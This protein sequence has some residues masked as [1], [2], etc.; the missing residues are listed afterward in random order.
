MATESVEFLVRRY[1]KQK[2]LHEAAEMLSA[3]AMEVDR[4]IG[5]SSVSLDS[6]SDAILFESFEGGICQ[7]YFHAYDCYRHWACNSLDNVKSELISVCYP[8][9]VNWYVAFFMFAFVYVRRKLYSYITLIRKD[10]G[11]M[12]REFFAKFEHGPPDLITIYG[13]ELRELS[14]VTAKDHLRPDSELLPTSG[15]M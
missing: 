15:F 7:A 5:D 10:F 14:K 2:G 9:F 13:D 3:S 1:L 6:I 12:A 8:L 4:K 11:D